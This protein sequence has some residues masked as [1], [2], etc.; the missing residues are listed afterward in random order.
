[1][2]ELWL[3]NDLI[4]IILSVMAMPKIVKVGQWLKFGKYCIVSK[5]FTSIWFSALKLV[6]SLYFF[7]TLFSKALN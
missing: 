7:K 6:T 5:L 3:K 2:N 4:N 1:M